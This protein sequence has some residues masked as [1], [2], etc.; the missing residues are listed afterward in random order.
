[1]RKLIVFI[2]TMV[3]VVAILT[4]F[5]YSKADDETDD[6]FSILWISDTQDMAY[7][8]YCHPLK[9]MGE[10]VMD[11][12]ES[13][14]IRYVVQTGDAVDNGASSWQWDRYDEFYDQ[15]RGNLPYISAA[16]NHEVKKNGYLE[17]CMREDIRT[18]PRSNTYKRGESSFAT[19]EAN[20]EK[21]IIVAIGFGVEQESAPWINEVLRL[22]KEYTAIL[23]LH[24][25]IAVTGN[26]SPNGKWVFQNIVEPNPNVRLVLCGHV[27]SLK[28]RADE[29]DDNQDGTPDRVVN[30]MLYNYQHYKNDCGQMRWLEFNTSDRTITVTTYSPYTDKYYKDYNFGNQS[31]FVIKDAF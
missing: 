22:H 29:V 2:L 26:F 13:L 30:A 24:D 10:W 4:P 9:K 21:F 7:H 31:T 8:E 18:I 12:A 16:G 5:G 19:F 23:I 28:A 15:I 11:N 17:Y 3:V 6:A 25:Y 1:M 20:G 14:D 27:T